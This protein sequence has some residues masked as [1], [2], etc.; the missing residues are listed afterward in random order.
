MNQE[1][2]SGSRLTSEVQELIQSVANSSRTVKV[3]DELPRIQANRISSSIATLYEQLRNTIDQTE[4]H[5]LRRNAIAR[6]FNRHVLVFGTQEKIGEQLIRELILSGYIPNNEFPEE[7]VPEIEDVVHK[8]LRFNQELIALLPGENARKLTTWSLGL[9][10][11]EIEQKLYCPDKE[12]ALVQYTFGE[13]QKR[14]KWEDESIA[15]DDRD[16]QLYIAIHRAIFNSDVLLVEY[17]LLASYYPEWSSLTGAD[18]EQMAKYAVDYRNIIREQIFHPAGAKFSQK[19]R[20]MVLPYEALL[21]AILL[22]PDTAAERLANQ[23]T[24]IEDI[25]TVVDGYYKENKRA[26]RRSTFRS[27]VFIF[28]T[29]MLLALALEIPYDLWV[30]GSIRYLPLGINVLFHPVYLFVMG[31]F[32][33]FP[34]KENT[35]RILSDLRLSM[36]EGKEPPVFYMRLSSK[37]SALQGIVLALVYVVMFAITFGALFYALWY[38]EFGIFG[39]VLFVLFLSIV[40]FFGI[41]LRQRARKYFYIKR[42]ESLLGVTFWFFASPVVEV[43]RWVS[44]KFARYNLFLFF[45]DI[46]LEAPLRGITVAIEEWF[47]FA[48]ERTEEISQ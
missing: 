4:Q 29:K 12:E 11:A 30:H 10:A 40:T 20:R 3:S 19:V 28:I 45:F 23:P 27:L 46:F 18:A 9:A 31:T 22:H 43:G 48:R 21:D 7:D 15:P 39:G 36:L 13:L 44:T 8:Y 16:I 41:R 33:K 14:I 25:V 1:T 37:R 42:K 47:R 26:T 32:V 24:Y 35:K 2:P 6:F 5:L 34:D 17:H 38:F